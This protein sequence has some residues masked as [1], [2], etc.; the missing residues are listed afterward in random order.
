MRTV[1]IYENGKEMKVF[2]TEQGARDWIEKNDPE[3]VAFKHD[4]LEQRPA[5]SADEYDVP[6]AEE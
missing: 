5:G 2:A 4:V 1:W 3:G 6:R